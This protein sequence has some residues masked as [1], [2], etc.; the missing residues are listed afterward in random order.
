MEASQDCF[1]S[2]STGSQDESGGAYDPFEFVVVTVAERCWLL[3]VV[4]IL[5]YFV[6]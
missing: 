2:V 3:V 4:V 6:W 5:C 1:H